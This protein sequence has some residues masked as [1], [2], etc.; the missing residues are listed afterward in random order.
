VVEED[1]VAGK[2]VVRLAVVFHDP[3]AVE[4]GDTIGRTWMEGR[5][6]ALRDLV[7]EAVELRGRR[8]VELGVLLESRDAHG[9]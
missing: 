6:L 3:K 8:L 1:P 9:L 2:H 7:N 5:G 4:L